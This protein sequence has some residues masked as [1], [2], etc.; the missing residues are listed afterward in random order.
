MTFLLY[1]E[2]C[3]KE[4]RG[5][6]HQP[7]QPSWDWT[8]H[9]LL[10][11]PLFTPGP[12]GK[13]RKP[14]NSNVS[15]D[16]GHIYTLLKLLKASFFLAFWV[17]LNSKTKLK[18]QAR[19]NYQQC[20]NSTD[21]G[22]HFRKHFSIIILRV[23]VYVCTQTHAI[24]HIRTSDSPFSLSTFMRVL[25]IKLKISGFGSKGLYP[26]RPRPSSSDVN[27][28][29]KESPEERV[30]YYTTILPFPIQTGKSREGPII[31][32][33]NSRGLHAKTCTPGA[34]RVSGTR[35]W[36][37]HYSSHRSGDPH[38][39]DTKPAAAAFPFHTWQDTGKFKQLHHKVTQRSGMFPPLVLK[40]HSLGK[41]PAPTSAT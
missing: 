30:D 17:K 8:P 21:T 15:T 39:A 10:P 33:Q 40:S 11:W 31:Y 7:W 5:V 13:T 38:S 16:T 22:L 4:T 2:V 23:C 37:W 18:Y 26:L 6:F 32:S 41:P 14:R 36:Y 3:V 28:H 35:A 27:P 25:G 34:H 29:F 1:E 9:L 24:T 19:Q 20:Q 12:P